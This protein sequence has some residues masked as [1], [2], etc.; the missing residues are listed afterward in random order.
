MANNSWLGVF[1]NFHYLMYKNITFK[2]L[3]S[4]KDTLEDSSV[5]PKCSFTL[6]GVPYSMTLEEW[7]N[8]FGF[9]NRG[10]LA[11]RGVPIAEAYDTWDLISVKG[12]HQFGG[13][14]VASIHN[15]TI[16]YFMTSIGNTIFVRRH[17]GGMSSHD[18]C[19]MHAALNP[20][21]VPK[22]ILRE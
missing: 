17:L 15:P 3:A 4:F 6:E 12:E 18:M 10:F 9:V 2:L 11:P 14:K 1:S 8:C 7:C 13:A 20:H 22:P 5:P 16:R 19:V 21:S